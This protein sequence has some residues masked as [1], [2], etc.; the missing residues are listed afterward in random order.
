M[1]FLPKSSEDWSRFIFVPFR[2]YIFAAFA[3]EYLMQTFWPRHGGSPP[4]WVVFITLGYIACF[5]IFIVAGVVG[6]AAHKSEAAWH[7]IFAVIAFIFGF[8]SLRFLASA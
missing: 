1:K 3:A 7:F 6:L 4:D 8:Y 2:A 5:F